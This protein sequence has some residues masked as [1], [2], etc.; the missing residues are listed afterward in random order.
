MFQFSDFEIVHD[1]KQDHF[2]VIGPDNTIWFCCD[3]EPEAVDTIND[4]VNSKLNK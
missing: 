2:N 1:E 3:N 4:Y